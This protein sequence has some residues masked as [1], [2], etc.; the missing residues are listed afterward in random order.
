VQTSPHGVALCLRWIDHQFLQ[1]SG[2]VLRTANPLLIYRVENVLTSPR[3]KSPIRVEDRPHRWAGAA[4][5]VP[6]AASLT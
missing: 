4:F 3:A 1:W 5:E 6:E 2:D